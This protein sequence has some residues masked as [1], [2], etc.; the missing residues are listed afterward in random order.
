MEASERTAIRNSFLANK[1][2]ALTQTTFQ[3]RTFVQPGN[4]PAGSGSFVWVL[5]R[6][7]VPA[8][9]ERPRANGQDPNRQTVSTSDS[10]FKIAAVKCRR[11]PRKPITINTESQS[12][13]DSGVSG[14]NAASSETVD[15]SA[16]QTTMET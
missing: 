13:S 5:E 6:D 10:V 16:D 7:G 11:I 14:G 3:A 15:G 8:H 1:L 4:P 2:G 12:D 9:W